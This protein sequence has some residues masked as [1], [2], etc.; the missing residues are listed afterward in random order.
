MYHSLVMLHVQVWQSRITLFP[1]QIP[2]HPTYNT[3]TSSVIA[4]KIP[5]S[6]TIKFMYACMHHFPMCAQYD[7]EITSFKVRVFTTHLPTK[8]S[9]SEHHHVAYTTKHDE[10][11][12]QTLPAVPCVKRWQLCWIHQFSFHTD[13]VGHC[14]RHCL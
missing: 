1:L 10:A 13:C 3:A 11:C 6:L 5:Y 9:E 7:F 4:Q 8:S 12:S 2:L 14:S